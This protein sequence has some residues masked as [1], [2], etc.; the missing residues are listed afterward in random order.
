M[1]FST[2]AA[3]ALDERVFQQNRSLADITARSRHDRFTLDCVAKLPDGA[4]WFAL[5]NVRAWCFTCSAAVS[6]GSAADI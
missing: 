3:K 2:N 5:G 6:E 4:R 1:I